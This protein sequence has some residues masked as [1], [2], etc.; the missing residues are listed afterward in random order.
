MTSTAHSI[1][2]SYLTQVRRLRAALRTRPEIMHRALAT[3]N[4]QH[5]RLADAQTVE[6]VE[7]SAAPTPAIT[8]AAQLFAQI[9][10][11]HVD[12]PVLRYSLRQKLLHQADQLGIH[13][14]EANLIIATIQHRCRNLAATPESASALI[15]TPG[16]PKRIWAAALL[17]VMIQAGI[18]LSA[19]YLL[20]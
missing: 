3:L 13:R 20:G 4:R 9:V 2:I 10:K 1:P 8:D 14:F 16:A 17:A 11:S 6:A 18:V 7:I 12:G 5:D 15:S 19:W